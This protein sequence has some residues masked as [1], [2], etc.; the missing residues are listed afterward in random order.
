MRSRTS[1]RM[2]T[3]A[4]ATA[5]AGL[6]SSVGALQLTPPRAPSG[7][8]IDGVGGNTVRTLYVVPSD[9]TQRGRAAL[10]GKAVE[11]NRQSWMR[12]GMTWT[13]EPVITVASQLPTD[14]FLRTSL[15]SWQ[16][17]VCDAVRRWD[18]TAGNYPDVC[19]GEVGDTHKYLLFIELDPAAGNPAPQPGRQIGNS[20][21]MSSRIMDA[22]RDD[23]SPR[24][25][26]TI[27]SYLGRSFG[28]GNEECA[29]EVQGFVC[30][31]GAYYPF[32]RL[33]ARDYVT[34]FAQSRPYFK[35]SPRDLYDIK[36][37]AQPLPY[38]VG[39]DCPLEC[40]GKPDCQGY[41]I[42]PS[43]MACRTYSSFPEP[44][45]RTEVGTLHLPR[46]AIL[47]SPWTRFAMK[48]T[49]GTNLLAERCGNCVTLTRPPYPD[50]SST[51]V[52]KPAVPLDRPDTDVRRFIVLPT[53][54]TGKIRLQSALTANFNLARC[55]GCVTGAAYPDI[56][57]LTSMPIDNKPIPPF[58]EFEI[59]PT[60][61]GKP[62]F[63]FRAD[64][65]NYMGRCNGCLPKATVPDSVMLHIGDS[66]SVLVQWEVIWQ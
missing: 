55:N 35:E 34:L 29:D 2:F 62:F 46:N 48:T 50:Y 14:W 43:T 17:A 4:T 38:I 8:R 21:V 6:M 65:G 19:S 20:W 59:F 61:A 49:D 51:L 53:G 42:D 33:R 23:L 40:L 5:L 39:D 7:L 58:A 66:G 12:Y 10:L 37:P 9:A 52:L 64:T 54:S 44:N 63:R 41:S 27:S 28:I 57:A 22:M 1:L 16:L 24:G 36:Q 15:A 32:N 26:G 18:S 30:G 60:A 31:E 45:P 11:H 56:V 25:F 13:S 3:F 47:P